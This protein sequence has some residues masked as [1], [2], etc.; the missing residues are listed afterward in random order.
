[1]EV[2]Y[3]G[4]VVLPRRVVNS[5]GLLGLSCADLDR[6]HPD[7]TPPTHPPRMEPEVAEVLRAYRNRREAV[8][9][10]EGG[11]GPIEHF[12]LGL[13]AC[14]KRKIR[15]SDLTETS[16]ADDVGGEVLSLYDWDEEIAKKVREEGEEK[17]TGCPEGTFRHSVVV[18]PGKYLWEKRMCQGK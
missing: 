2:E 7:D 15:L 8:E 12:P 13:R 1:M 5:A 9:A 4:E 11:A 17:K 10:T 6:M 16:H 14:F 3:K 18:P